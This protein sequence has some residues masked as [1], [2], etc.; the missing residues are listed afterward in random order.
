[1]LTDICLL[2]LG[3]QVNAPVWYYVLVIA[4]F[5]IQAISFGIKVGEKIK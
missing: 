1:M 4:M 5:V 3:M 2:W